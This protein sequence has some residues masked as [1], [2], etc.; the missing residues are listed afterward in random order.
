MKT[1]MILKSSLSAALLSGSLLLSSSPIPADAA[2]NITTVED[3]ENV[4]FMM[5]G[6]LDL[7]AWTFW[8]DI[9]VGPGNS[10]EPMFGSVGLDYFRIGG[11]LGPARHCD[12]YRDP[13]HF[14][15]PTTLVSDE[16][17]S[18]TAL[19]SGD[20]IELC[21]GW[22]GWI[23]QSLAVTHGYESGEELWGT[24]TFDGHTFESLGITPGTYRWS[25][26]DAVGDHADSITMYMVPEPSTF[27]LAGLGVAALIALR[28]R[29]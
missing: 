10:G 23:E 6:T 21:W 22:D 13:A 28:R 29:G 8:E 3:D 16:A 14:D 11:D 2:V 4:M 15:G 26:S 5:Y 19:I 9:Y 27:A 1:M 25:W 24:G 18:G 17:Y 7:E 20:F 12:Y